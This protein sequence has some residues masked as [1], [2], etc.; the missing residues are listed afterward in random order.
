M[1]FNINKRILSG[2]LSKVQG[3]TSRK[4]NFAITSTVL[5][6][7]AEQ[8]I[9]IRATDQENSFEGHYSAEVQ[10]EGILAI[11]SRKFF[12]IIRDMPGDTILIDEVQSN[13]VQI[14]NEKV[15]YHIVCMNHEDFPVIEIWDDMDFFSLD[16]P[17]FRS[18]IEKSVVI[19]PISD[20]P[21][22][23]VAGC[24]LERVDR[25]NSSC[26]RMVSTDSSRLSVVDHDYTGDDSS[27]LSPGI[28]IS[29]KGLTELQKFLDH[30]DAI[31]L[32][33]KGSQLVVKMQQEVFS[34]RLL[35]GK[36]P[37]YKD[38]IQKAK[39][40]DLKLERM[41]F[42]M[43]LKRM[44]ILYSESS[45][46]VIFTFH[47]NKL[48]VHSN[49]PDIGESTE[50]IALDYDGELMEIAFNPRYFI[51]ALNVIDDEEVLLRIVDEKNPCTLQGATDQSFLTVIMPMKL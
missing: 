17:V 46:S 8:K 30:S 28:I 51:D 9:I 31:F 19:G 38:I 15:Q 43:V 4:T 33:V 23:H 20:D 35:E 21:R 50:D 27:V 34:V 32:G 5:V 13:W 45:K 36:F 49:N 1:K 39:K 2:V 37:E 11:N 29:K 24:L 7:A 26:L 44:S 40:I 12:E 22:A 18:M 47:D 16:A 48:V 14:S 25:E 6:Q 41:L 42:L 3:I 10:S